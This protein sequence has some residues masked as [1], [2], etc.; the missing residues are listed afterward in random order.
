MRFEFSAVFILSDCSLSGRV[1]LKREVLVNDKEPSE[2]VVS[3]RV[4]SVTKVAYLHTP[5][6]PLSV[7][8]PFLA[9]EFSQT[10]VLNYAGE[11]V[12]VYVPI[13]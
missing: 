4:T 10:V 11:G 3:L 12:Y 13:S 9:Y 1:S 7:R 5:C 8:L 2:N 6:Y